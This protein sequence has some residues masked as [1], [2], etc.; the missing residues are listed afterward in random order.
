MKKAMKININKNGD[1]L[2]QNRLLVYLSQELDT[3]LE[4]IFPLRGN[5]FL[6][7]TS[8]SPIILKGFR[9]LKKLKVQEAFTSSLQKSGFNAT[10]RFYPALKPF[11]FQGVY[12]ACMEYIEPSSVPFHFSQKA[13]RLEGIEL[14]SKFHTVTKQLAPSFGNWLPKTDTSRKWQNRRE[15]FSKNK[16]VVSRYISKEVIEDYI[17]W[18]EYSLDGLSRNENKMDVDHHS[19]LHGD[20]AHHN[21]LREDSGKLFLIDFDLIGIGSPFHDLLQYANR[22]LPFLDWKMSALAEINQFHQWIENDAFLYGL[23]YPADVLREWN[24][25]LRNERRLDFSTT[26]RLVE[27]TLGQ[28]PQRK[29]FGQDILSLLH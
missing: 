8:R 16:E 2:F 15:E 19:V 18:S 1:D 21:F 13:D 22:I 28:F 4:N 6:I 10:Y 27:M 23:L 14:L 29:K 5:V 25:L 9:E 3:K 17:L 7:L 11:Y 12:Y 26:A 20:V 24:R